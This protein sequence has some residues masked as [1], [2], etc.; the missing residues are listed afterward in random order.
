M[1]VILFPL[2]IRVIIVIV[3]FLCVCV[4]AG[5]GYGYRRYYYVHRGQYAPPT[6]TVVTTGQGMHPVRHNTRLAL[7]HYSLKLESDIFQLVTR[8]ENVVNFQG[9]PVTVSTNLMVCQQPMPHLL[10]HRR[11]STRNKILTLLPLKQWRL[12]TKPVH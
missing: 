5:G 1:Y 6:T 9:I 10:I 8:Y 7:L 2:I 4:C 11:L 12:S 3:I